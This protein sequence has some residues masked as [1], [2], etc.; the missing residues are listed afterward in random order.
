MQYYVKPNYGVEH[1]VYLQVL[2]MMIGTS[3]KLGSAARRMSLSS[4]R[5]FVFKYISK[6]N[7][8]HFHLE[9]CYL[10]FLNQ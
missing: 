6:I 5:I 4:F 8:D 9:T 1:G 7:H 10:L 3:E 2:I